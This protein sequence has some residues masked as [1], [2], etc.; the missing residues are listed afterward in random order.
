M[1]DRSTRESGNGD[2]VRDSVLTKSSYPS[3][4]F[5][6]RDRALAAVALLGVLAI[7]TAA[8]LAER[9]AIR[10]GARRLIKEAQSTG[11]FVPGMTV[12]V[13]DDLTPVSE[14]APLLDDPSRM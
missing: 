13:T 11:E 3:I 4:R 10:R 9:I 1:N 2:L 5:G 6:S 7:V 8:I 12:S 14:P